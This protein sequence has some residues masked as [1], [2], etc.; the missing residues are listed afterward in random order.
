MNKKSYHHTIYKG[1]CRATQV[2][3]SSG[4]I[5]SGYTTSQKGY[6]H[7]KM[8]SFGSIS[9]HGTVLSSCPAV[10][11]HQLAYRLMIWLRSKS[12]HTSCICWRVNRS[13]NIHIFIAAAHSLMMYPVISYSRGEQGRACKY[14]CSGVRRCRICYCVDRRVRSRLIIQNAEASICCPIKRNL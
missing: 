13:L 1:K 12:I 2:V 7:L 10:H 6:F 3:N 8:S 5:F 4:I 9:E 14:V 11:H